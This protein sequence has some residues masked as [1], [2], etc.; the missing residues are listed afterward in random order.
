M[1]ESLTQESAATPKCDNDDW[2]TT[3]RKIAFFEE[4]Y[5]LLSNGTYGAGE[6][7]YIG[8]STG[9][10]C[11]FCEKNETETTFKNVSHAIPYFLGNNQLILNTECDTCNKFFSENLETHLD[12]YTR[13]YRLAAQIRGRRGVPSIKS[14][15]KKSRADFDEIMKISAV[16][17]SGFAN[18]DEGKKE[19]QFNAPREPYIPS[20]V[21]KALCKIAISTI[22]SES[23]VAAF[24]PT[25]KWLLSADHKLSPM[26][27]LKVAA[28]FVPGPRPFDRVTTFLFR[29][30]SKASLPYSVFVLAFGNF[31]YQLV[32]PALPDAVNGGHLELKMP[33]FPNPYDKLPTFGE[34]KYG[35]L[36]FSSS[37]L[38]SE[39]APIVFSFEQAVRIDPDIKE[40]VDAMEEKTRLMIE[41]AAYYLAEK[42]GFK[43][44]DDWA[45]WFQAEAQIRK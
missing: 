2:P 28:T 6:K 5:E 27:P 45:D 7:T 36:D 17:D 3:E 4:H 25:I 22:S 20:A 15:D 19:V 33:F 44:G 26:S 9:K 16:I 21:Y 38:H 12:K 10:I 31:V 40:E 42:R 11:R 14:N 30:K 29:K 18:I 32:V 37:E 39:S 1:D 23:A 13:P 43:P 34:L 8:Q 41:E 35:F 24:K